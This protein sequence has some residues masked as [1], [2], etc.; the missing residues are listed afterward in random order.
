MHQSKIM[1][2]K[3]GEDSLAGMAGFEPANGGIKNRC[4]TTWLHPNSDNELIHH[5]GFYCN[6]F[7]MADI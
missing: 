4:L 5:Y 2:I 7:L 3:E 6:L 1:E